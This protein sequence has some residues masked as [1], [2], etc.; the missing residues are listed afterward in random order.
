MKAVVK[1]TRV[2]IL[3]RSFSDDVGILTR[4]SRKI[5]TRFALRMTSLVAR[6]CNLDETA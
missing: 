2:V 4:A 3:R 1:I 6:V 5:L